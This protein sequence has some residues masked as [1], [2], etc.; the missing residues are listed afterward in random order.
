MERLNI[1]NS[2]SLKKICFPT[3]HITGNSKF[4]IPCIGYVIHGSGRF[5]YKGAVHTAYA[6]DLIYIAAGTKYY[7]VWSG[8]GDDGS[9]EIQFYSLNYSFSSPYAYSEYRFQIVR[10]F[11]ADKFH[12]LYAACEMCNQLRAMSVLYSLLDDVYPRLVPN[13]GRVC[14]TSI[15]AA[16]E[17]I[18]EHF[19]ESISV[20]T[21]AKLCFCSESAIYKLFSE[22]VGV[23]PINYKHNMM[24]SHALYLIS[25][26][27]VSIEEISL[28]SGFSSSNY[29]RR[30][31]HKIT[32]SNPND[33]R[34]RN[35]KQID[36]I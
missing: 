11:P 25:N 34:K 3:K 7:S 4:K 10:A 12:S 24:V 27:D 15:S 21:L 14:R 32:G 16:I 29:F 31:F 5:L 17:Y 20:S 22:S 8:D 2:L 13:N 35:K 9:G 33:L 23:S 30:V 1:I 18:E 36:Q 26:T 28:Q 6:G 19:K